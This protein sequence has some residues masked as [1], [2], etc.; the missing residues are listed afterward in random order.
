MMEA[1]SMMETAIVFLRP[2]MRKM[3]RLRQRK[4]AKFFAS[5]M[6]KGITFVFQKKL[7]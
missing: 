4:F 3:K 6:F 1:D 5:A 7:V 2:K